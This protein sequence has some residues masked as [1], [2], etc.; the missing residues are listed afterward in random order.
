MVSRS[1]FFFFLQ[2]KIEKT[3][4]TQMLLTDNYS[5]GTK[6]QARDCDSSQIIATVTG[7]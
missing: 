4:N 7:T 5:V 1:S 2:K 6:S 3:L